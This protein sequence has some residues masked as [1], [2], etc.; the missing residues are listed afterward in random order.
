[1]KNQPTE[2]LVGFAQ[3]LLSTLFLGGY[4]AVMAAFLLGYVRTSP[5]WRD[6]LIALLGVITGAVGTIMSFWFSRARPQGDAQ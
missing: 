4:F 1:M 2:R 3:I 5:E 6:A